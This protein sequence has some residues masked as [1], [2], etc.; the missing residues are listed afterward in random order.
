VEEVKKLLTSL[1]L[2]PTAS[3]AATISAEVEPA[4]FE[5]LFGV[6]ASEVMPRPPGERDFGAS[7]GHVSPPLPVPKPLVQHVESISVAPPH[8]YLQ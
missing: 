2:T 8:L 4:R 6:R 3:G 1:G 7:G 5:K